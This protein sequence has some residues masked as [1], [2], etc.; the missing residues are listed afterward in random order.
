[1]RPFKVSGPGRDEQ[2]HCLMELSQA[3]IV[4][5]IG[6]ASSE[7]CSSWQLSGA[8]LRSLKPAARVAPGRRFYACRPNMKLEDM[9]SCEAF[10][11]L[12]QQGFEVRTLA[13]RASRAG[14][15]PYKEGEAKVVSRE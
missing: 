1:M 9:T 10:D 4:E 7:R 2:H 14:L 12:R 6:N 15:P 5:H 13:K 3:G 8:G 11:L